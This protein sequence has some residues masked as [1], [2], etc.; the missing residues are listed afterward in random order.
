MT[1]LRQ[2]LSGTI[3]KVAT[4]VIVGLLATSAPHAGA[5]PFTSNF[6]DLIADLQTRA[7]ALSNSVDKTQQ[8]QFK[9]I[10][11]VLS[12][13]N[14]STSLTTDIKN[15]GSATKTLF[16]AF[17]TDYTPPGS[18]LLT[19]T[20]T[21]LDGLIDNV[22]TLINTTETNA[23]ALTASCKIKA[24]ASV[25]TAQT[26]LDA[27]AAATDFPTAVKLLGTA[28]KTELKA[29]KAVTKCNSQGSGGGGG[30][31]G[32]GGT[33][34]GGSVSAT[35]SGAINANFSNS[36]S[37]GFAVTALY[38][39][40][41][42]IKITAGDSAFN[43][44]NIVVDNVTGQGTYPIEFTSSYNQTTPLA[45]SIGAVGSITFSTVDLAH[46]K[47]VGTFGFNVA[48]QIGGSGSLNVSGGQFNITSISTTPIAVPMTNY[49]TAADNGFSFWGKSSGL[50][51]PAPGGGAD[52][53]ISGQN[54]FLTLRYITF[55]VL[56]PTTIGV[57]YPIQD[58]SH[59][60][61]ALN[62]DGHV[63]TTVNTNNPSGTVVFTALDLAHGIAEGTFTM[64]VGQSTPPGSTNVF[65]I[66][67][68]HFK[69]NNITN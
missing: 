41:N 20:E 4:A 10:E 59:Y 61:C 56:N 58:G 51:V 3:Y 21:A 6:D 17:P 38:Q 49:M 19:N 43:S 14:K 5:V 7:G 16:K 8:K 63:V 40:V 23:S 53:I 27:A 39:P 57:P 46:Q 1:T 42:I 35:I 13:L 28:L 12:T 24:Q 25:D 55:V 50:L 64:S 47:L 31:G 29:D 37:F 18:S 52:L 44:I 34:V 62:I 9:T 26:Q 36:G 2:K 22:Q 48:Q 45:T 33:G 65:S 30:G 54:D 32:G 15:L 66:V 67:N 11:K 60:D 68:G 69:N